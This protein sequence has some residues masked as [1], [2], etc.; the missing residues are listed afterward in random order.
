MESEQKSQWV[1]EAWGQKKKQAEKEGRPHGRHCPGW[2]APVTVPH[3]N[4]NT[5]AVTLRYD[6]RGYPEP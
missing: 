4:D 3:P 2:L 1:R 5:R 6:I